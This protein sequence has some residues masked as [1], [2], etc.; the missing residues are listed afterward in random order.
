MILQ[1]A[2][3]TYNKMKAANCEVTLRMYDGVPRAPLLACS[4]LYLTFKAYIYIVC[5]YIR[6]YSLS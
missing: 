3:E 1:T 5:I 4:T 6:L 2:E